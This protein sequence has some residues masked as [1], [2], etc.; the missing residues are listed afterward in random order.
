MEEPVSRSEAIV[1]LVVHIP[2]T[3][4]TSLRLALADQFGESKVALDYGAAAEETS[5]YIRARLYAER[6]DRNVP[7]LVARLRETGCE[8]LVGHFSLAKYAACFRPEE[9][10]AFVREP[11]VRAC[12]EYLHHRRKGR[13]Q[14]SFLQFME[15]PAFQNM[16]SRFLAGVQEGTFI[17][18]TER[19][20]ASLLLLNER[21][22][23]QLA[24]KKRNRGL[25]GGGQRM[26]DGLDP[27]LAERFH[28]LN[29]SDV[30]LYDRA[31]ADFNQLVGTDPARLST[32]TRRGLLG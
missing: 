22:G 28:V 19:Y 27:E 31:R 12:S 1:L 13:R 29:R 6:A 20:K 7:A 3:A 30:D 18:L 24:H 14:G 10:V 9:T 16:Q 4:G 32:A 26:A 11:L 23:L 21:F 15:D 2:K 5:P 25:W 8:A 17:G